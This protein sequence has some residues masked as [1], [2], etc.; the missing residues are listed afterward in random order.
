MAPAR[1]KRAQRVLFFIPTLE[2]GGAERVCLHYVNNLRSYRPI[3]LLQL[4][5]GPLLREVSVSVPLLEIFE[6]PPV[7]PGPSCW[8]R[9]LQILNRIGQGVKASTISISGPLQSLLQVRRQ[10]LYQKLG[11]ILEH[12]P[13]LWHGLRKVKVFLSHTKNWPAHLMLIGA[14]FTLSIPSK[15][16]SM[17][18]YWL[19]KAEPFYY[20]YSLFWQA[21]RLAVL[22]RQNGCT[23]VIS[24]ITLPNIIAVLSKIFFDRRLKVIINVHDI[25]SRILVH[26]KLKRYERFLLRWLIRLVYPRAD[27]IVAVAEGIKRDLV[28]H[29][30]I[31]AEKIAVIY[32]P[33]DVQGIRSRAAEPVSHPWL[34]AKEGSLVVAVGRLVKLKGFDVLIRAFSQLPQTLNARLIIIGE[35]EERERLQELI[36]QLGL[37]ERVALLG[38]QENPW[39]YMVRADVFV[40]SSITEGLPNVIAEAMALGLPVLATDCSLG[41]R[42]LLNDGH[43]GLLVRP[44]DPGDLARGIQQL[45]TDEVL[46]HELAKRGCD[47]IAQLDLPVIVKKYEK[48][49]EERCR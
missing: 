31:P 32:N 41:V 47:R 49:L 20:C 5:R 27:V 10:W 17:L 11:K 48:L 12:S 25:T 6:P 14:H 18:L 26:S 24:F 21:Y 42:E 43:A 15:L 40:L 29:F 44:G 4:K 33:V 35:G 1:L 38:F 2:A 28:V 19:R 8:G 3:L 23:T 22:A 46:R 34:N 9:F 30:K 45:L 13:H 37:G 7:K 39:K 36:E 16:S